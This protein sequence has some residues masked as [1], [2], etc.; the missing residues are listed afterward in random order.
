M[1]WF[2]KKES[3]SELTLEIEKLSSNP[4][5]NNQKSFARTLTN[6]VEDNIWVPMPILEDQKGYKLKIVQNRGKHFAAMYSDN[7]HAKKESEFNIA[8]TDINKLIEA[9]FQNPHIDGIVINPYTTSL[10]LEKGYLLKCL[11]HAKYPEQKMLDALP[12]I[13][14]KEFRTIPRVI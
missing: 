1:G 4:S 11:L 14:E 13:G 7:I 8:V 9:V 5:V 12:K 10:C 6:Y 3:R 2:T